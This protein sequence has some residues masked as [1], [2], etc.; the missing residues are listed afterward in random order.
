MTEIIRIDPINP[1][2][3]RLA[4]AAEVI[5]DGGTVAFPTETVYGLGANGFDANACSRIFE[6]K[7]R[8]AD[9]PLIL[10]IAA[11]SWLNRVANGVDRRTLDLVEKVW[12][13]PITLVLKRNNDV[14]DIVTAGLKTAAIRCPAHRIA[15]G[16]IEQS[17]VPIAA[18]SANLSTKPSTTKFEHVLQ[19]LDGKVDV[20]ID[21][22][23]ATF[24]VE[25]TIIDM[26]VN[27][28]TLLR[29]G[30]FTVEEIERYLGMIK[31]PKTINQSL[32]S[33]DVAI[34]PGMKYRHYAPD[35]KLVLANDDTLLHAAAELAVGLKDP[36]AILCSKQKA[37]ALMN[38]VK[39]RNISLIVLGSDDNLYEVARN[40]FDGFRALDATG[41]KLG[42]I[43]KFDEKG[44]G[45]AIMN[46]V[47]KAA[48][49]SSVG[50]FSELKELLN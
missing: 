42:I 6:I 38:G 25:S 1:E 3:G 4:R 13:G 40:L 35:K 22:G 44:I 28:P 41:A 26:T 29:P 27:P 24:G 21:G 17:G 12:P 45:L 11:A 47:Y 30:A 33:D 43:Q 46:R 20:I 9:N 48:G 49:G 14:P 23:D 50:T 31:V 39:L 19:D 15:L 34:A 2:T 5:K 36:I 18:P 37:N 8:P 32:K 10:H 7:G 16:L